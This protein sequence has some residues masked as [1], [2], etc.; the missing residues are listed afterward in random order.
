MV[1]AKDVLIPS[2][3]PPGPRV[4]GDTAAT[5]PGSEMAVSGARK[6]DL[7]PPVIDDPRSLA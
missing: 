5:Q 4:E 3:A 1:A 2:R 6:R 7:L